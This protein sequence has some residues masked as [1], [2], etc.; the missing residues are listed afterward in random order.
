[1]LV[2]VKS[3]AQTS[4]RTMTDDQL[5]KHYEQKI[6]ET[7]AELKL[8]Q[9][10]LKGD[11]GNADIAADIA[12]HKAYIVDYKSKL[13]TVNGAIKDQKKYDKAIAAAEKAVKD[14]KKAEEIAHQKL[15][16]AEEKKANAEKLKSTSEEAAR[17]TLYLKEHEEK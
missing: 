8:R 14:A 6:K 9:T 16:I 3:F 4:F 11:K 17:R 2:G 1:M 12:R 5:K 7:Q 15:K 10:K 13:K